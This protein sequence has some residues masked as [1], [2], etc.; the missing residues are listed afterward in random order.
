MALVGIFNA[1]QGLEGNTVTKTNQKV[2]GKDD[3]YYAGDS[4]TIEV[5]VE[6]PNGGAF[7]LTGGTISW[8]LADHSGAEADLTDEDSGVTTGIVN[9]SEG[10][11]EVVIDS[12]ATDD[13]AGKKY[14]EL[15][16]EAADGDKTTVLTG[17][18]I[19][20]EDTV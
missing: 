16:V 10:R 12:G 11:L 2:G 4:L 5:T 6:T 9:A 17:P 1:T 3:P 13:L 20:R 14:H 19:I 8:A 7:D 18:F 15:E